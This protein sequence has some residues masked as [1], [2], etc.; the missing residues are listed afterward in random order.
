MHVIL[1]FLEQIVLST[2]GLMAT[3]DSTVALGKD[4]PTF[5][6]W[7]LGLARISQKVL[8]EVEVWMQL[9]CK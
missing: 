2:T 4:L 6:N 5:T 8:C 9:H 7:V 1:Y 3:F